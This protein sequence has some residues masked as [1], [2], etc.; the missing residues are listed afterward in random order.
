[1][2]ELFEDPAIGIQQNVNRISASGVLGGNVPSH[3]ILDKKQ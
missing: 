3:T 2:I 1:M